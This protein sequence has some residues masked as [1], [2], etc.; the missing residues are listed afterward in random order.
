MTKRIDL[1]NESG[2]RKIFDKAATLKNV[3]NFG[4]GQPDFETPKPVK[5]SMINAINENKTSYTASP[6]II[7]LREKLLSNN[8]YAESVIVTSGTSAAIFLTYSAL[9]E[10]NDEII[11][12]DPYFL[13][14]PNLARFLGAKPVIVKTNKDFSIDFNLLEKAITKKT[15]AIMLNSPSNPTGYVCP[16]KELLD[17]AEFAKKHDLW[18]ISDEIYQNFDY[19]K[20]FLSF[21]P[22]Y[23]K[24]IVLNGFSKSLAMAG[25]RIGYAL[26]PKKIIDEMTKLQQYTFVCAPSICQYAA[27]EN[28][29]LDI[30][31]NVE[32]FKKRRD[33]IYSKLKDHFDVVKPSGAFYFF[34][35]LP[36]G[37]TGEKFSELCLERKVL[38]VPGA[39]FSEKDDHFRISYATN[40]DNI[41]KGI[42]IIIDAINEIKKGK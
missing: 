38:V 6:G 36:N 20:R 39:P 42:D 24:T 34:V 2:I 15:K 35:K 22:F 14:Y 30:T 37:I 12:F 29:N 11:I 3:I 23:K 13:I 8:K 4:I 26:G 40:D 28:L 7:G 31:K 33:Y 16:K 32:I 10:E 19:E 5:E 21:G 9:L 41:K 17:L 27:A 1:I 18:V 25:L